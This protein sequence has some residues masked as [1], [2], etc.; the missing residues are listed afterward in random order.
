MV[1]LFVFERDR[2]IEKRTCYIFFTLL[3]FGTW[4]VALGVVDLIEQ[5]EYALLTHGIENRSVPIAISL[6]YIQKYGVLMA[7]PV[8]LFCTYALSK[9]FVINVEKKVTRI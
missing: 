5:I 7:F 1:L 2:K 6:Y 3:G 8:I 4:G 9:Y